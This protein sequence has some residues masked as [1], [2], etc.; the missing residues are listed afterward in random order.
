MVDFDFCDVFDIEIVK[1]RNF[2][3]DNSNDRAGAFLI[4]ESAAKAMNV[5]EPLGTEITCWGTTGKIVGVMKDFHFQS[6]YKEIGPLALFL[7]PMAS[8]WKDNYISV[9]MRANTIPETLEYLK[10]KMEKFSP[11]YPLEYNFFDDVFDKNY[12]NVERTGML[13]SIFASISIFIGC[14]GFLGLATFI[15]AQRTKEI[16]IRKVL[17]ATANHIIYMLSK[18][19]VKWVLIAAAIAFPVG[20]FAMN[21]W[22]QNFAYRIDIK[23]WIFAAAA[24]LALFIALLTIS[25]QIIKAALSNPVDSLRYE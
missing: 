6:F 22:L 11:A 2:S 5:Q 10:S 8:A 17:G 13:F 15:S 23:L 19:F 21:N 12:R 7:Y 20:W 16:G 3:R 24:A 4:N 14:L 9:K 18:K 25:Y 1:G